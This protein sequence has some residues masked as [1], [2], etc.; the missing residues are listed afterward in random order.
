[1]EL[2]PHDLLEISDSSDLV[3]HSPMPDWVKTSLDRAPFVVVR[4]ARA[5]KNQIAVGIR[6]KQRNQ[7]FAAF[8]PKSQ[9]IRKITPEQLTEN[10][11]WK[12]H[13]RYK[14][15]Q[16]FICLN[17]IDRLLQHY[18]FLW[19]PTGSVG[20]ELASGKE[21]VTPESD[22]DLIIRT[23]HRL[24]KNLAQSILLEFQKSEVRIDVQMETPV[25]AVNLFE[26]GKAI[27]EPVLVKTQNGP[28]LI[29]NPWILNEVD[30]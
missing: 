29:E 18:Q 9:F 20:F 17:S 28:L 4:R 3:I 30:N 2:A 25:G 7:R 11:R 6:G 15:V 5:P 24:E 1:M 8:L 13:H 23:P 26:Y 19:G 21:T 22:I 12:Q 14:K 27:R 10:Q 16:A